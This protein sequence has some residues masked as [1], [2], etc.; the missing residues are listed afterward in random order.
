MIVITNCRS[1]SPNCDDLRNRIRRRRR[2]YGG[3]RSMRLTWACG[4]QRR[5]AATRWAHLG[6]AC[7]RLPDGV[8]PAT[9]TAAARRG[10]ADEHPVHF[11]SSGS[12]C[13]APA[14]GKFQIS[15]KGRFTLWTMKLSQCDPRA[16]YTM[17]HGHPKL[18]IGC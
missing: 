11:W 10:A 14:Q 17:D 16:V 7:A 15:I 3:R 18:V 4:T 1:S 6:V 8:R 12:Q 13:W 2:W 5:V 9:M